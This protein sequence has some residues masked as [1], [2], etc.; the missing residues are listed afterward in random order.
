MKK[1]L[2]MHSTLDRGLKFNCEGI[3]IRVLRW[4]GSGLWLI[5]YVDLINLVR[6]GAPIPNHETLVHGD[7]YI[8]QCCFRVM[9]G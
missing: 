7:W 1:V 2:K 6:I 3:L 5:K 4:N 8:D 9:I